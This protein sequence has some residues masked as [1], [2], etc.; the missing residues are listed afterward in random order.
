MNK[1]EKTTTISL[2]TGASGAFGA[3][4]LG[5]IWY[6]KRKQ[7]TQTEEIKVA[8]PKMMT[9]AE[10]AVAKRDATLFAFKTLGYGTLLAFT[11]A[12]LLAITV[13]YCLDVHN[14]KE[15]SD[16]LKVIIPRHTARLRQ[17]AGGSKFEMTA[18]EQKELDQ[19]N[20]EN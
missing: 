1:E 11:G 18:E 9:P 17:W 3:G 5:A 4:L 7:Q 19:I 2:L 8:T 16:R 13:G 12:G 15:F 6:T 20:L 10:Y 14:F